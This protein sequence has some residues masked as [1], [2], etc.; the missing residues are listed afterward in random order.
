MPKLL[1]EEKPNTTV[2]RI[3]RLAE[4]PKPPDTKSNVV[5]ASGGAG[6]RAPTVEK[7]KGKLTKEEKKKEAIIERN[8][9]IRALIASEPKK[10]DIRDYFVKRLLELNSEV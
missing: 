4:A 3:P 9:R 8:E 10:K 5:V 7:K 2:R 6:S 1:G